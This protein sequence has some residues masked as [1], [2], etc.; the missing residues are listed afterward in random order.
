MGSG[1]FGIAILLLIILSMI[2]KEACIEKV[3]E[4]HLNFALT[5]AYLP[6]LPH[7]H[8]LLHRH[9]PQQLAN[10]R[11][12]L[13]S[14]LVVGAV[15]TLNRRQVITDRESAPCSFWNGFCRH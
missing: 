13:Q 3:S 14:R 11:T 10:P 6:L 1:S 2:F 8:R 5:L 15:A 7:R 9:H 12:G 4:S